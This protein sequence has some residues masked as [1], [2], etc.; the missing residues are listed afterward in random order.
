MSSWRGSNAIA[1][2]RRP[3]PYEVPIKQKNIHQTVF[4]IIQSQSFFDRDSRN[5]P[6]RIVLSERHV[7]LSP[8]KFISY[9]TDKIPETVG[10]LALHL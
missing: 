7:I 6:V 3:S 8:S 10:K 9:S 5:V 1:S 2:S 4:Y